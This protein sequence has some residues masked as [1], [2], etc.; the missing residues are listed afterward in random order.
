MVCSFRAC[1]GHDTRASTRTRE[2]TR[3]PNGVRLVLNKILGGAN[4][5][6]NGNERASPEA[7]R[8]L[9]DTYGGGVLQKTGEAII[10]QS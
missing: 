6:F 5:H 3:L 9:M 2:K 1:L 10:N 7:K 4:H 8:L